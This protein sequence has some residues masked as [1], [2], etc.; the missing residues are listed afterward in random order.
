VPAGVARLAGL[1][2]LAHSATLPLGLGSRTGSG[3]QYAFDVA[4]LLVLLVVVPIVELYVFIQVSN[5]IGFLNALGIVILISII[6]CWLVKRAG[7]KVWARFNEQVVA[8]RT[9]SKEVAD[10]VCLLIAGALLIVPGFVTDAIGLLLLLPPIRSVASKALVRR[11]TGRAG[12]RV[13]T[14]TYGSPDGAIIDTSA[15]E[16]RP[17]TSPP[18]ELPSP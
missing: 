10:G 8:Q 4:L 16:P 1:A 18:G 3:R 14:A 17:P 11:Y 12:F 2:A 15:A 9:P 6:G 7:T 5:A 13:I